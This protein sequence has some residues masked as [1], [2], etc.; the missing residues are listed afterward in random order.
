MGG[1]LFLSYFTINGQIECSNYVG[2]GGTLTQGRRNGGSMGSI[3]LCDTLTEP[4]ENWKI[5]GGGYSSVLGII[6]RL[7]L[8]DLLTFVPPAPLLPQFFWP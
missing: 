2:T 7:G 8:T 5:Q 6:C 4:A 3:V 1:T